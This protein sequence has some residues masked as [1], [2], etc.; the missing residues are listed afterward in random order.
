[1][2]PFPVIT[3]SPCRSF[4]AIVGALAIVF[5]GCG[6]SGPAFVATADVKTV[7]ADNN[8]FALDLY[9]KLK[10]QSGNLI[11]SPYS[12]SSGAAMTYAGARTQT[13]AELAQA[14]HFSLPQGKL[15][16]AFG[17]LT[18]RMDKLQRWNR[19]TLTAANSLWCQQ[20][21]PFTTAFLD[22][23]AQRYHAEAQPVDFRNGQSVRSTVNSW[24]KRKTKAKISEV[25]PSGQLT[26]DTRLL[27]CSAIYFKGKWETPFDESNTKSAPFYLASQNYVS[28]P[29]MMR[30]KGKFRAIQADGVSL[31]ELPYVGEDLS[32]IILLPDAVDGL[33][34]LEQ[35]LT[36]E[37]LSQ[38]LDQLFQ[39]SKRELAVSLP[40][41]KASQRFDL[42]QQLM[43][44]GA[45]RLFGS[46]ADLSGM[47]GKT[48]LFISDALHLAFIEVNESGT[49]AAAV[50]L[51][52]AKSKGMTASFRANHPFIYLIRENQ[53]GS[54]LFLGRTVDPRK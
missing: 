14:L 45:S 21:Y 42:K 48:D 23:V 47:N 16:A 20:D 22:L 49:E 39:S 24:I 9:Q 34:S 1:M 35:E 32:M 52:Q 33:A 53:T 27:L 29:T 54:I 41:F 7:A 19:I 51:F 25:I 40:R 26:P 44:L 11:F 50:T 17:D 4:R 10:A 28:V 18:A 12:I 38:W 8:G 30:R 5:S 46:E 6:D 3:A 31:L 36:T 15:H 37:H 2:K 43:A 13:E